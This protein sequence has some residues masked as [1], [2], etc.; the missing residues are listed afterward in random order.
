LQQFGRRATAVQHAQQIRAVRQAELGGK[1]GL[2]GGL[3]EQ[4]HPFAPPGDAV[5]GA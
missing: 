2:A 4:D 5:R 3:V 1:T